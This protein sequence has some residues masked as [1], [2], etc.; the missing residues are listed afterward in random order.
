MRTVMKIGAGVLTSFALLILAQ[1]ACCYFKQHYGAHVS[2][3]QSSTKILSWLGQDWKFSE[4]DAHHDHVTDE[5]LEKTEEEGS[6]EH[7]AHDHHSSSNNAALVRSETKEDSSSSLAT[8]AVDRQP[9]KP[10]EKEETDTPPLKQ[11][12]KEEADSSSALAPSPP[13]RLG[14]LGSGETRSSRRRRGGVPRP[15][16]PTVG[17]SDPFE[18]S[19]RR[20]DLSSPSGSSRRRSPIE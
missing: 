6:E 11:E 5:N 17:F 20:K 9:E 18:A 4:V 14:G 10:V 16:Q 7:A 12:K 15:G 13:R 8:T 3:H 2:A 19:R 1:H